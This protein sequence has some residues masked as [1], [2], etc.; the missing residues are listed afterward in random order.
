[1]NIDMKTHW[2][3]HLYTHTHIHTH[4]TSLPIYETLCVYRYGQSKALKDGHQIINPTP[5]T[6]KTEGRVV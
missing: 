5:L 2:M 4:T 3:K 6:L 1:M